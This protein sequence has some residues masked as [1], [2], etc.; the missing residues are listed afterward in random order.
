MKQLILLPL[1]LGMAHSSQGNSKNE[2]HII[3][4]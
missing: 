2:N 4:G 1:A 3:N